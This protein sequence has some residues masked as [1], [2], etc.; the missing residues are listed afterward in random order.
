MRRTLVLAGAACVLSWGLPAGAVVIDFVPSD[1]TV[2]LGAVVGVDLVISDLGDFTAPSLGAFDLD[3]TYDPSVLSAASVTLTPLLGDA[4]LGETVEGLDLSHP[5]FIDLFIVSFLSEQELDSLQP[6]SFVL[7]T[8][9]F[10]AIS[11]G[12]SALGLTQ[13][14]LG[15][16]LGANLEAIA[17]TGSITVT[18]SGSQVPEPSA[19]GLLLTAALGIVLARQ[20]SRVRFSRD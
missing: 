5:G 14:L 11:T 16:A 10:D 18:G 2:P 8:F 15:D 1:Q 13:L 7:A 12:T 19:R 3:L 6:E 4:A 20:R 9:S 17:G